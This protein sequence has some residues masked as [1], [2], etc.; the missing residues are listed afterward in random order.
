MEQIETLGVELRGAEATARQVAQEVGKETDELR[1]RLAEVERKL[2]GAVE[3]RA[4]ILTRARRQRAGA[5]QPRREGARQRHRALRGRNLLG[6]PPHAC[7]P[8]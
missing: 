4:Q 7:R 1:A 8:K 5:L 2:A 6:L 3:D